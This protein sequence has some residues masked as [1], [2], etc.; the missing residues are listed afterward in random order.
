VHQDDLYGIESEKKRCGKFLLQ[1]GGTR[2]RYDCVSLLK[3][4]TTDEIISQPVVDNNQLHKKFH[5]NNNIGN[6]NNKIDNNQNNKPKE[7]TV[8]AC[9][10][11]G[12]FRPVIRDQVNK[13]DRV[14]LNNQNADDSNLK[15]ETIQRDSK[16][17]SDLLEKNSNMHFVLPKFEILS[18]KS[19]DSGFM[20]PRDE[21]VQK[22]ENISIPA[23]AKEKRQ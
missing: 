13:A 19:N 14:H 11:P 6:E 1:G 7:S 23:F 16:Y 10:K 2:K 22:M 12:M 17:F 3:K 4:M 18:S 5:N 20:F 21:N 9:H 15:R 8:F